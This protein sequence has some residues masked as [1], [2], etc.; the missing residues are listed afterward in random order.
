LQ[1]SA[2]TGVI[3]F[4]AKKNR[5]IF[6]PIVPYGPKLSLGRNTNMVCLNVV[7]Q[8]SSHNDQ[9]ILL[10]MN[11]SCI[12]DFRGSAYHSSEKISWQSKGKFTWKIMR[13]NRSKLGTHHP[14]YQ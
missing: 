10:V 3:A 1:C 11:S 6:S 2:G 4:G 13:I 7:A 5:I 8:R 14:P 9:I 12:K